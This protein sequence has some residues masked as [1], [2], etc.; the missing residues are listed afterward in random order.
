MINPMTAPVKEMN[1]CFF[2][3]VRC[4]LGVENKMQFF[5]FQLTRSSNDGWGLEMSLIMF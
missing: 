4:M 1:S 3:M 5:V 2:S